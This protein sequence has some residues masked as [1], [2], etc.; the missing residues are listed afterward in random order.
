MTDPLLTAAARRYVTRMIAAIAPFADRL[1]RRYRACLR[2]RGH[3]PAQT[4]A[5]LAIT[6][7][8]ASR[9]RS[10][11]R[12]LEQVEY[13]GRR[14]AKLNL[15]P[16]EVK[17]ILRDVWRLAGRRCCPASSQPAREQLYLATVLGPQ[18]GFL[19]GPRGRSAGVFRALSR[20]S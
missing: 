7:A 4:R 12:F 14:L 1:E 16:D 10:L 20:R 15:Q 9:W 8:A 18:R 5:F 3:N 11:N 17:E 2:Q 13:N 19:P 6:P